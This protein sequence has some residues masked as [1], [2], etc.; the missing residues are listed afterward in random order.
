VNAQDDRAVLVALLDTDTTGTDPDRDEAVLLAMRTVRV[1][2]RTGHIVEH[3]AS[4][5]GCREPSRPLSARAQRILGIRDSDVQ[6]REFDAALI[7]RNLQ[8]CELVVAHGAG[9]DRKFLEPLLPVFQP[10]RWACARLEIDWSGLEP[11]GSNALDHLLARIDQ[12]S[13][14]SVS[15][16]CAALIHLL[17]QPLPHAGDTGFLQLLDAADRVSWRL[18]LPDPGQAE[19]TFLRM[20]GYV[21]EA[22]THTW[23]VDDDT[24]EEAHFEALM[25]DIALFGG[26]MPSYRVERRDALVRHSRREGPSQVVTAEDPHDA[27]K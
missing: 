9:F 10:L 12:R 19:H 20:N 8:D 27:R 2:R 23:H 7:A 18:H 11:S 17:D 1:H 16:D 5:F 22:S 3:V 25:A 21:H 14:G 4:Y 24:E 6:G 15:G 13:D 26:K